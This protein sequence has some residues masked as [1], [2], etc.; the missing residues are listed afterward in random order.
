M[1]ESMHLKRYVESHP[2]NKMAWYLL[3]KDYE[4][5]G[6]QGKANYCFNRAEEVYEA[7]ELSKAPS[8]I[9]KHY[10]MKLLQQEKNRVRRASK[11]RRAWLCA[12]LFL[13]MLIPSATA[14]GLFPAGN[15]AVELEEMIGWLPD[16]DE[17]PL[18][19]GDE[20]KSR[21]SP[22]V[23]FTAAAMQRE[24]GE[25]GV[26]SL[27]KNPSS[28][29]PKSIMLGME[30]AGNW[31]M[32]SAA[33]PAAYGVQREA[34]GRIGI[35]PYTGAKE[36]CEC[37]PQAAASAITQSGARWAELQV[38]GAVLSTA[39]GNFQEAVGR[40][41]HDLEE[42]TK[43]FPDNWLA[44]TSNEITE[45]FEYFK[46]AS[47]GPQD[48]TTGSSNTLTDAELPGLWGAAPDG[49][50]FFKEDLKI[51]IDRANHRLAVTSGSVL[52][53]NYKVGLGEDNKTPLGTFHIT[54]KVVHPNGTG[55]GVYGT[56]GMQLSDQN[57]AIHGTG[58][59]DSIGA[60]E[61]EGCIRMYKEDVEELFD[62]VPMGTE[63]VIDEGV[64]P[65]PAV[66]PQKRFALEHT[67]GQNNP[68]KTYDWL[69]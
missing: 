26:V 58:D 15:W 5:Q 21:P 30:S 44:G 28:L 62:L 52:L 41:P 51:V 33:M 36:E 48:K 67:P 27:L 61:S 56:R 24:S 23:L 54:D 42:L 3:G 31:Q 17:A 50:L 47:D 18:P 20:G 53:R 60:N 49:T 12:V 10:E 45:L 35:T 57:Y 25:S 65:D 22:D 4:R 40:P 1:S 68:R 8:D 29:P 43:P 38:Q 63:V 13:L 16:L 66:V 55:D 6:E 69:Y 11:I 14:P 37:E 46:S 7:F 34:D 59:L 2:D 39:I 32:W 19:E 9:W 64:L